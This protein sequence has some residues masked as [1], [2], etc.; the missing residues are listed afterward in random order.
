[1]RLASR[2]RLASDE[3]CVFRAGKNGS[4]ALVGTRGLRRPQI[5]Q[6]SHEAMCSIRAVNAVATRDYAVP[7]S[8]DYLMTLSVIASTEAGGIFSYRS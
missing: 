6:N 7:T 3:A 4:H 5:S 1:M 8:V 2:S